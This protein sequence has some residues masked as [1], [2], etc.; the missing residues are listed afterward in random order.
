MSN[1]I[2]YEKLE[3]Y[4]EQVRKAKL[5]D[6]KDK[7]IERLKE[8]LEYTIPIVEHNKTITKHLK[9]NKRLNN[10]VNELEKLLKEEKTRTRYANDVERFTAYDFALKRLQELKG[11]D[12]E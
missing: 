6:E 9:E 5:C 11:E 12:K 8:E 4:E 2:Y 7:E 10:I 3:D 1:F